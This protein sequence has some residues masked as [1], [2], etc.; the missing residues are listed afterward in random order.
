MQEDA[1]LD[2]EILQQFIKLWMLIAN[3]MTLHL[4]LFLELKA[5][6]LFLE[7]EVQV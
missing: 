7:L 4:R 3:Q 1:K 2:K 6:V 5:Q